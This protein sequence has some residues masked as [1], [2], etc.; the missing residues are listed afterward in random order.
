MSHR[1][2]DP[3]LRASHQEAPPEKRLEIHALEKALAAVLLLW[4]LV[5]PWAFGGRDAPTQFAALGLALVAFVLALIP[6]NIP[7]PAGGPGRVRT[8]PH[9]QL[10]RLP[11]FWLGSALLA[12]VAVQAS[13]PAWK[14]H[15]TNLGWVGV[16]RPHVSWLPTSFEAPFEFINPWRYLLTLAPPVLAGCAAWLGITRRRVAHFIL[17]ALVLNGAAVAALG[18]LQ[19]ATGAP[20]AYWRVTVPG[21]ANYASFIYRNHAAAYL[22][23]VFL[24]GIG[25]ALHLFHQGERL[26]RRSTPSP[27]LG[28]AALGIAGAI[29]HSGSRG[30]V[31]MLI[32]SA[33]VFSFFAW[34]WVLDRP[35]VRRW[36]APLF[37]LGVMGY[38]GWTFREDLLAQLSR[39]M[40]NT[41]TDAPTSDVRLRLYAMESGVRMALDHPL[42]G[43]GA[44]GY[45]HFSRRYLENT[46]MLNHEII[47][48]P[49]NTV[50]GL[51]RSRLVDCH[52]DLIQLIAELG[53]VGALLALGLV[54]WGVAALITRARLHPCALGSLTAAVAITLYAAIDFPTSSAAVMA[55]LTLAAVL[56]C[57][58]AD[59]EPIARPDGE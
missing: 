32:L 11:M 3:L 12:Y 51:Y 54:A 30:G 33:L 17:A 5:Q 27:V 48:S 9:R 31:L 39:R 19:G 36:L 41:R 7:D 20:G 52:S 14:F 23:V 47:F 4:A 26:H 6:R 43:V 13:N 16:E 24:V 21:S 10:V 53:A 35:G 38:G 44:A 57:R 37:L 56:S 59:L 2:I 50:Y 18:F 55:S 58:L 46:P 28:L 8:A 34:R 22:L 45:Q 42:F 15:M 40:Q 29:V 1:H 49:N 25:V